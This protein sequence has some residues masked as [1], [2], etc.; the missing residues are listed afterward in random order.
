MFNGS[1]VVNGLPGP[2]C[3]LHKDLQKYGMFEMFI[4]NFNIDG[5]MIY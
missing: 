4:Y 1:I 2:V 5:Y 3:Q